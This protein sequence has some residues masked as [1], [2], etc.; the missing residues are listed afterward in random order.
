MG[1][2]PLWKSPLSKASDRRGELVEEVADVTTQ[3]E[4]LF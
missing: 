2:L 1:G 3:D 4:T